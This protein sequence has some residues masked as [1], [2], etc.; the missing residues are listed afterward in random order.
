MYHF[1]LMPDSLVV[2]W[3]GLLQLSVRINVGQWYRQIEAGEWMV[4][5]CWL[6]YKWKYLELWL[7]R[8]LDKWLGANVTLCS[9]NTFCCSKN[10]QDCNHQMCNYCYFEI[11]I[12][13]LSSSVTAKCIFAFMLSLFTC[14]IRSLELLSG[15][16][17]WDFQLQVYFSWLLSLCQTYASPHVKDRCISTIYFHCIMDS[18]KTA[19]SRYW[20]STMAWVNY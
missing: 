2:L 1:T 6:N 3:A 13:K 18:Y 11:N 17:R 20:L 14:L 12:G 9:L 15:F 4:I 5:L 16:I 8:A 10:M 19:P 7:N